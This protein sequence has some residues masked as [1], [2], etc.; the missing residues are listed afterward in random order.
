MFLF[1]L[2]EWFAH[3]NDQL[4]AHNLAIP[5]SINQ[6]FKKCSIIGIFIGEL[7]L[8][9]AFKRRLEMSAK[10][11]RLQ[12]FCI[13]FTKLNEFNF[14]F[15]VLNLRSELDAV[16]RPFADVQPPHG[17]FGFVRWK[18]MEGEDSGKAG[19]SFPILGCTLSAEILHRNVNGCAALNYKY[20]FLNVL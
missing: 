10:T 17:W 3:S 20:T 9:A 18:W 13:T 16:I 15:L 7:N 4:G 12:Q 5:F 14:Y 11:N 1:W 19:N 8:I 2:T 6:T